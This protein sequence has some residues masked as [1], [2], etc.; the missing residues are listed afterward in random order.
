MKPR[1][2]VLFEEALKLS[3]D[4][5]AELLEVLQNTFYTP[6]DS[7]YDELWLAEAE[8]RVAA[9]KRGELK[10]VSAEEVFKKIDD[11]RSRDE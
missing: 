8:A 11:M 9:Y 2:K 7:E 1:V 10:T 6:G 3:V 5:R 4:E